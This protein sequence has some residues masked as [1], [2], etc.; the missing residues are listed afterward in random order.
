MRHSVPF[1]YICPPDQNLPALQ[2]QE[3][4]TQ[5]Q[6]HIPD[7]LNPHVKSVKLVTFDILSAVAMNNT[8]FLDATVGNMV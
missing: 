5:T 6:C 7:D 1:C 2:Y 3:P 4:L 8:V